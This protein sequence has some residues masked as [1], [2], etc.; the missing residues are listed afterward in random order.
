MNM[1]SR[2]FSACSVQNGPQ[3]GKGQRWSQEKLHH[4]HPLPIQF[5]FTSIQQTTIPANWTVPNNP[6]KP[7]KLLAKSNHRCNCFTFFTLHKMNGRFDD[8]AVGEAECVYMCLCLYVCLLATPWHAC[9][10]QDH[11]L[12][13]SENMTNCRRMEIEFEFAAKRWLSNLFWTQL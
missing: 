7:N 4:Y 9:R 6:N 1:D 8:E 12:C 5:T 11:F 3:G 13:H 10:R 2:A